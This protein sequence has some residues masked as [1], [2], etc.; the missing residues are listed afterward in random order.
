VLR[1]AAAPS[2]A[3]HEIKEYNGYNEIVIARERGLG[4]G[5][6]G[7]SP[8]AIVVQRVVCTGSSWEPTKKMGPFAPGA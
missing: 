2:L 7:R 1:I 8:Y 6:K 4:H 5:D 3:S